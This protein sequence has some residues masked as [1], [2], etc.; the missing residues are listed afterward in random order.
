MSLPSIMNHNFSQIPQASLQRSSFDRSF[1]HKTTMDSGY[2][3]P[4]CLQEILPGDTISMDATFFARISTM[5]YPPM[6]N[7]FF[8][9]FWFFVPNR[10][11]WEN[12]QKFC[13]ERD[14]DPD[15]SIDYEIPFIQ[16]GNDPTYEFD[17]FSL[18]DYFGL[19]TN[20]PMSSTGQYAVYISS[21]PFRGYTKIYNEWFRDQNMQSV[22][23]VPLNDGP[24]N[25]IGD[26]AGIFV[27]R[28]RGKR[29]DYFTSALPWPQKGDSVSIPLGTTAP[30]IGDGQALGFVG[31]SGAG[32]GA[33]YAYFSNDTGYNGMAAFTTTPGAAGAAPTVVAPTSTDAYAGLSQNPALSHAFADLSS[34]TAATINQLREAFAIQQLLELDAR[35]GTRYVE[36][37][38][39]MW[40]VQV[41]DFRL[42]RPEYLGGST[43]RLDIRQVAQTSAPIEGN[44]LATL[45]AYGQ[46]ATRS[47]FHH[48]FVEHGY[49]FCLANVR[50]DITYQQGLERH[51]SRRDRYDFY[52]PVFAHLGE[53]PIYQREIYFDILDEETPTVF[54]YQERWA[55]YRYGKSYVTGA[56]RSNFPQSLDAWHLALD[57]ASAPALDSNFIEDEPPIDRIRAVQPETPDGQQF[58]VDMYFKFRHSRLMPIYSV[59]GLTRL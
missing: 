3:V 24:D 27:L 48:S 35:G 49:L 20:S 55:E 22:I 46:I 12:W 47:G 52:M 10:I 30:V 33:M 14:P 53:Q 5:L 21:L 4:V 25:P 50:A 36:Q 23:G 40:G 26:D 7:I 41:P 59:P 8:D 58:L 9:T 51:W 18:G 38:R 15:S 32:A 2:L 28:K 19:P 13:G 29:H 56:F 54:G 17:P 11:V 43:Q 34:A 57:F 42:Q 44:P 37:L 39:A 1:G 6:D 31:A 16:M 45:A